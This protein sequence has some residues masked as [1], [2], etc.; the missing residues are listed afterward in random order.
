VPTLNRIVVACA[1]APHFNPGMHCV[2]LAL[3]AV[4]RRHGI[5]PELDRRVLYTPEELH[6][7]G[8]G[9]S[10]D[11]YGLPLAYRTFRQSPLALAEADTILFWGDFLHSRHYR[12]AVAVLMVRSGLE[13]SPEAALQYFDRNIFLAGLPP[14]VLERTVV[15]GSCLLTDL[16]VPE[17]DREYESLLSRLLSAA[18]HVETRDALSAQRVADIRRSSGVSHL[19]VDCALLLRPSECVELAGL[20]IRT[21]EP[22]RNRDIGVF[23][24][25]TQENP[26]LLLGLAERIGKKVGAPLSWLPWFPAPAPTEE[27]ARGRWP[28]LGE[29]TSAGSLSRSLGALL[30]CRAVVTDVYHL[31]VLAWNCGIPAVCVGRGASRFRTS[32][33]DKKK[34]IFHLMY[35]IDRLY[36]FAEHLPILVGQTGDGSPA[37]VPVGEDTKPPTLDEIAAALCDLEWASTV[38]ERIAR[39]RQAAENR[40]VPAL[41]AKS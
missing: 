23:F 3:D 33:S 2:D 19:G 30:R 14:E 37:S 5:R 7:R 22:E 20:G 24:A 31:S 17:P 29:G 15:F 4:L 25:R 26:A 21:L 32:V 38:Q 27:A 8:I 40:L 9:G 16:G 35:G 1:P 39:Q 18:R 34:E 36:T 28:T 12:Q 41:M 13:A 10:P 11:G 6:R